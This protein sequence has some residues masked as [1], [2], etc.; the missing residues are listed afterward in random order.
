MIILF[1]YKIKD[2]TT[3]VSMA[4]GAVALIVIVI[5]LIF[6]ATT[7][8]ERDRLVSSLELR[9]RELRALEHRGF[10]SSGAASLQEASA[11]ASQ[12]IETFKKERL[13]KGSQ[14]T[15][16]LDGVYKAA[17]KNGLKIKSANY[18]PITIKDTEISRYFF[19]FPVEGRY[20]QVK[21]FIFDIESSKQ[22][23]LVESITMNSS[24]KSAGRIGVDI[25]LSVYFI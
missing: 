6:G 21:K 11:R 20:N 8:N 12:E 18:K 22:M 19:S 5:N 4:A 1:G 3:L 25:E 17:R 2:K 15:K 7:L 23:L 16:V 10:S 9:S 13:V 24:Q 14:L